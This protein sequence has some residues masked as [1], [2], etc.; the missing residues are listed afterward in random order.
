ML[1]NYQQSEN[2]KNYN[3]NVDEDE[4]IKNKMS[5]QINPRGETAG[6]GPSTPGTYSIAAGNKAASL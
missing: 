5:T 3:S 4:S 2:Y 1:I 6:A